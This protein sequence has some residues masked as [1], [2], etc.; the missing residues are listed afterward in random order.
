VPW[1]CPT[2][3]SR[4]VGGSPLVII[5]ERFARIQQSELARYL[6]DIN[7]FVDDALGPNYVIVAKPP[8]LALFA[9]RNTQKPSSHSQG[10]LQTI[11]QSYFAD[12]N[13]HLGP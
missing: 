2:Q 3:P 12:P 11:Q 10:S 7:V 4:W 6:L 5:L 9:V 1:V 13:H 8:T